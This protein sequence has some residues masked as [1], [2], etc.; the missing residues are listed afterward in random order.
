MCYMGG[1]DP[2]KEMAILR[3]NM[4]ML[5]RFTLGHVSLGATMRRF[6]ELLRSLV[7]A[8]HISVM[9]EVSDFIFRG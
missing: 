6:I 7:N 9:G 1:P 8:F 3:A 5:G 4:G 2:P